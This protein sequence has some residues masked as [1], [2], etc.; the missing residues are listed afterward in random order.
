M[1]YVPT[2]ESKFLCCCAWGQVR[3]VA[4]RSYLLHK[5]YTSTIA[6][7]LDINS[8]SVLKMLENWADFVLICGEGNLLVKA[9]RIF[10]QRQLVHINVGNDTYGHYDHPVLKEIARSKVKER[11]EL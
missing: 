3:S 7:G 1:K 8:P 6:C 5:G 11:F 10:P 2:K 4:T 9:Q